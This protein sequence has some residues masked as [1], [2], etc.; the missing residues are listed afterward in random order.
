MVGFNQA[1]RIVIIQN[2]PA[3]IAKLSGGGGS[4]R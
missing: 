1:S 2:L 3:L 4:R